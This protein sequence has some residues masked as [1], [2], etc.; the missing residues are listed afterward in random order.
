M[1]ERARELS[2]LII[3]DIIV[4]NIALWMTLLVRYFELPTLE[5]L[6]QHFP[7]FLTISA[8]WLS[9]FF[10]SGLYDKHTNLLKK[11]MVSRI[12]SAQILNVVVAGFLFFVLPF[13]ITPKTN[14][15]IYLIISIILLT[16]WRLR[17]VPLLSPKQRH[18]A[19]LIADGPEAIELV[20]E[21]NNNDRYNY[22]FI[23]I[24][25]GETLRSTGDFEQKIRSLMEREQVELIVADSRGESIKTFLPTLF[26]LSF[27]HFAFTFLDFNRLYEDTFDRV[28]VRMLQYEWFI[29]NIS[30]SKK[31]MYDA[32]KRMIDVAGALILLIPAALIFPFIALVIKLQDKG[33]LFY[34]TTRVGQFNKPIT[35][36][37]FR[38]KNG[39]DV[40][41]AALKSTLTDT[42][43]G[44]YLRKLRL[45]ELPQLINV[46]RG[47]LSFIGPRPEMPAL[48]EVYAREI[49]YYNTRHFLKPGLSGWAQINNYDVPRGGVDVERTI[50]KLSYDLYYLE[51]RS[52][53]LDIHIAL[54]T[55]ATILM[56][57]G[58]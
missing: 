47:D 44:V 38:T 40:G 11:F 57:T 51:R 56:R 35:I 54:K 26:N 30:Q 12:L 10:I 36:Y 29:T 42:R 28:P 31:T 41:S 7:P 13:G 46:L 4:F 21:I 25:D 37:K 33:P 6:E 18:K 15:I 1:G 55:I 53:L 5:R 48:A 34:H 45:D 32:L 9:I 27:L 2:V 58:T 16:L 14:L 24:I 43:M 20:D 3:G 19:I 23:R 22:Y 50:A 17:A 49:P 52:L 8:V 39:T